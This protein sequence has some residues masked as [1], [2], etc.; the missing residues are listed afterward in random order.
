MLKT[1]T[2]NIAYYSKTHSHCDTEAT[3]QAE[4]P[5]QALRTVLGDAGFDKNSKTSP[6]YIDTKEG[7]QIQTGYVA[8][9]SGTCDDTG[10]RF[11]VEAWATVH[12]QTNPFKN[13][14]HA[15]T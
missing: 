10:K 12:E 13:G 9:T 14:T 15:P 11:N 2:V 4:T 5:L 8:Q 6:M 1:Y 7:E 3:V